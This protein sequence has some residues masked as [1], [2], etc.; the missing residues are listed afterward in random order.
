MQ[1]T[2]M[3]QTDYCYGIYRICFIIGIAKSGTCCGDHIISCGKN[4]DN[5]WQPEDVEEM[6]RHEADAEHNNDSYQHLSNITSCQHLTASITDPQRV[7]VCG[8]MR[9]RLQRTT[10]RVCRTWNT[11]RQSREQQTTS[12]TDINRWDCMQIFGIRQS[13]KCMQYL[14]SHL[15]LQG[16]KIHDSNQLCAY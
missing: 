2:R 11:Q 10:W 9:S 13:L 1:Y 6:H 3:W 14:H 7:T 8:I 12:T 15:Q 4:E 5:S 16:H